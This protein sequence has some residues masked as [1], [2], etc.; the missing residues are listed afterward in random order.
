MPDAASAF[1]FNNGLP[2]WLTGVPA[3]TAPAGPFIFG[4]D[5][6]T[7]RGVL[8]LKDATTGQPFDAYIDAASLVS[9]VPATQLIN[10]YIPASPPNA[11]GQSTPAVIWG[12][13]VATGQL[14]I[15]MWDATQVDYQ[16]W[17]PDATN[18]ESAYP[19]PP[20]G[21]RIVPGPPTP[22][23]GGMGVA[24]YAGAVTGRGITGIWDINKPGG[25]GYWYFY[26]DATVLISTDVLPL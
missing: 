21:S 4:V 10:I 22:P 12:I 11:P 9:D 8:R 15:G 2:S 13:N 20:A 23:P 7:G 16:Y 18:L 3:A 6:I 26:F 19:S 14:W 17:F 5:P 25:A 24:L 1:Y